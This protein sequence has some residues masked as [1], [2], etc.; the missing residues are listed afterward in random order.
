M[1]GEDHAPLWQYF[2]C[3]LKKAD[4]GISDP[5]AALITVP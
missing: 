5:K 1:V 4:E 3:L 2:S